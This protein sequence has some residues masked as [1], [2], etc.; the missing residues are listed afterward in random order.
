VIEALVLPDLLRYVTMSSKV[1]LSLSGPRGKVMIRGVMP[2][3]SA[4]IRIRAFS[5][6]SVRTTISVT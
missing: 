5:A 1:F 6:Q 3:E 4:T 2:H